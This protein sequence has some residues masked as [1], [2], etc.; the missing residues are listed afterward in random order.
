MTGWRYVRLRVEETAVR[1]QRSAS[2]RRATARSPTIATTRRLATRSRWI[3]RGRFRSSVLLCFRVSAPR[4]F[5][6]TACSSAS[7]MK[8]FKL[9]FLASDARAS[10]ACSDFGMRS[11]RRP[12]YSSDFPERLSLPE[13]PCS[14]GASAASTGSS[15]GR[16]ADTDKS[17]CAV[18][19]GPKLPSQLSERRCEQTRGL[20]LGDVQTATYLGL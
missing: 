12:L 6:S 14:R 7:L 2:M 4:L 18:D 1:R 19:D 9:T 8:A 13:A 17:G 20:A 3:V 15:L 16:A 5:G 11:S 10:A